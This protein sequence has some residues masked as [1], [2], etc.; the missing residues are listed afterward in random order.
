LDSAKE[1]I[2]EELN[3]TEPIFPGGKPQAVSIEMV[4]LLF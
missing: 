3:E 4:C 2:Q 1:Q